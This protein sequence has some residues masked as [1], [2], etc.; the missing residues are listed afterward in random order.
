MYD[1][2][3]TTGDIKMHIQDIYVC[4]SDRILPIAK[5]WQQ[6]QLETICGGASSGH[7]LPRSKRRRDL[8]ESC[9]HRMERRFRWQNGCSG[10]VIGDNESTKF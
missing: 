9:L 2:G 4:V 10:Y 5:E 3:T 8:K 6:R 7:P 1:K